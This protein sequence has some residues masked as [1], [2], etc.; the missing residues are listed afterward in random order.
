M[1]MLSRW[2]LRLL[3]LWVW[4][5]TRVIRIILTMPIHGFLVPIVTVYHCRHMLFMP[6]SS[7]VSSLWPRIPHHFL[8][9]L[10]PFFRYFIQKCCHSLHEP[11]LQL[12]EGC[13]LIASYRQILREV[14]IIKPLRHLWL[15]KWPLFLT[16]WIFIPPIVRIF[17]L[18]VLFAP[19]RMTLAVAAAMRGAGICVGH[20]WLPPIILLLLLFP[21]SL[22]PLSS[23]IIYHSLLVLLLLPL[24]LCQ[25]L[26]FL[27]ESSKPTVWIRGWRLDDHSIRG[28]IV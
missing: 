18:V 28:G 4:T 12:N 23:Y 14:S 9:C 8:V 24:L 6:S 19:W 10:W 3:L 26:L 15:L 5:V 13:V 25:L 21:L 22:P 2:R 7:S 20:Q 11:V 27:R 1:V 17:I 16:R